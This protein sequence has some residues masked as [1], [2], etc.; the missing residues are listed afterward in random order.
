[1]RTQSHT[2]PEP[3]RPMPHNIEIKARIDPGQLDEIRN[4]AAELSGG[5]P[6]VLHQLD[7]FFH[8]PHGRLKLREFGDG[9]GELIAYERP[10][11][12]GPKHSE[13][14]LAPTNDPTSLK[15]AL[16]RALGVRGVVEKKRE[17][18]L[19]GQTRVHIDEVRDLGPFLELEVMLTAGQSHADGAAIAEGLMDALEVSKNS[20]TARAYIDLLELG[21]L[22]PPC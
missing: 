18:S 14:V 12:R 6:T 4:R 2:Q 1:M 13:F 21:P 10:D 22:H 20:L 15:D 8:A 7:T 11:Q 16:T 3:S 17:L 9:T 19:V 5:P